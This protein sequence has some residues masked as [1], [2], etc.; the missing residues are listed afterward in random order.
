MDLNPERVAA[1]T[2]F[3]DRYERRRKLWHDGGY[4]GWSAFDRLLARDVHL[5]LEYGWV[6]DPDTESEF[7]RAIR[8]AGRLRHPNILPI[9]DLGIT[10]E[11]RC[12][13]TSPI[14]DGGRDLSAPLRDGMD[15]DR[16]LGI[17]DLVRIL[18]C[19]CR[20]LDHAHRRGVLHL[21]VVP[22]SVEIGPEPHDVYLKDWGLAK[23][24]PGNEAPD[25][26]NLG[27]HAIVGVLS[28]M[29]PEQIN[30]ARGGISVATDVHG[31]G[32]ILYNILYGV[33]PNRPSVTDPA[34]EAIRIALAPKRPRPLRPGLLASETSDQNGTRRSLQALEQICLH[35]LEL[36]PQRRQPGMPEIIRELADW[37][38]SHNSRAKAPPRRWWFLTPR[39]GPTATKSS[40]TRIAP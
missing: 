34:M 28:Y 15:E 31:V 29:A 20:A 4:E 7:F 23:D 14:I 3:E 39:E 40:L 6:R 2:R 17:G 9:H 21:N 1:L 5:G 35:A 37:L 32:A 22:S 18:L 13:F 33:S 24:V 19:V 12:Y 36:N 38:E 16:R 27:P 30:P 11:G 26:H 8:I 10:P 25:V